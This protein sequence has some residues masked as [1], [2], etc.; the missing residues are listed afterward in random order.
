MV[1]AVRA[2]GGQP[3]YTEIHAGRH[4]VW[5]SVYLHPVV[6]SWLFAPG[7]VT[8]DPDSLRFDLKAGDAIVDLQ[9]RGE[10]FPQ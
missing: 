6:Q 9:R 1:E 10:L 5:A 4:D 2:A 8:A 3:Q 7:E